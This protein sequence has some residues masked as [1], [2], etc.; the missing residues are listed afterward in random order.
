MI[1][2]LI[3]FFFLLLLAVLPRAFGVATTERITGVLTVTNPPVT[4]NALTVN[5]TTRIW[6][7]T[8]T[9]TTIATNLAGVNQSATNLYNHLAASKLPGPIHVSM[10]GPDMVRFIANAGDAL[11]IT[12][13]SWA[14]I[15]YTTNTVHPMTAVRTPVSS[16][17]TPEGWTNISSGLVEA[18]DAG[19]TNSISTNAIAL[20]HYVTR[21]T[22]QVM[23][24][25]VLTNS[26]LFGAA[27]SNST[28]SL[29]NSTLSNSVFRTGSVLEATNISGY[30]SFL[31][32][33]I[34]YLAV[35]DG[36]SISNA[37]IIATNSALSNSVFFGGSISN[38]A[39][40]ASNSV[41]HSL[42]STNGTNYGRAFSSPGTLPGS[43][44]FAGG[45][46]SGNGTN[47]IAIG[48]TVTGRS[49]INVGSGIVAGDFGVAFGSGAELQGLYG[50]SLGHDTHIG[51]DYGTILG[52]NSAVNENHHY[53]VTIGYGVGTTKSNQVVVG[54]DIATTTIPGQLEVWRI[55]AA[56]FSGSITNAAKWSEPAYSVTTLANGNNIALNFGSNSYVR[57]DGTITADSAI[58]G[59]LGG[60]NGAR[61]TIENN[62][63]F[64]L[65][66]A[67]STA[68][69]TPANRLATQ[70]GLDVVLPH[71]SFAVLIYD[72]T[73]SRWNVVNVDPQA[74]PGPVAISLTADNTTISST[75]RA[76]IRISS[77]SGTATARTFILT[78]GS[79]AG[80][81]LKIHFT[82]SNAAELVDDSAGAVS[83][84]HRLSA[85]WTASQYDS[86]ALTW[87]GVDWIEDSRSSN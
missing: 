44:Q 84:N 64:N 2:A 54:S 7:N 20:A 78:P 5:A 87:D 67:Q 50:T 22:A 73:E 24:N 42:V 6:T 51:A 65:S 3:V 17:L 26:A 82:G 66:L 8:S 32:N 29:T 62:T 80:Q 53:S 49:G 38:A 34:W 33:G 75:N 40:W 9:A 14:L 1:R 11:A 86:I 4:G 13:N 47:G 37:T 71:K 85:T 52:G 77:D 46:V 15:V 19:P 39:I 68:D 48:G 21:G 55:T 63:G 61:F 23:G 70:S 79:S 59:I 25:K 31:T 12:T 69:P 16:E 27:I 58:C 74:P 56:E 81:S 57:L 10:I 72:S 83:G 35:I 30:V 60:I 76:Y 43:Q 45:T 18:I 28:A 41:F 36:G